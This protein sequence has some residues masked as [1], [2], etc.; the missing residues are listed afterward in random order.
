[1]EPKNAN[2]ASGA[3]GAKDLK[4][5]SVPWECVWSFLALCFLSQVTCQAMRLPSHV[6]TSDWSQSLFPDSKMLWG[7]NDWQG[8]ITGNHSSSLSS[9]M[10]G[11]RA[12]GRGRKEAS[13]FH[14]EKDAGKIFNWMSLRV[15][16]SKLNHLLNPGYIV[17]RMG[18]TA[19]SSESCCE[20][21]RCC[22]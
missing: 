22:M 13:Q 2:W 18:M 1:M 19:Y 15:A 21:K 3:T 6:R 4:I 8:K 17:K 14:K 12:R 11:W 7:R 10:S 9:Y 5:I 20:D 16:L